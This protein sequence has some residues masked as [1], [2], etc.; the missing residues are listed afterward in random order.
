MRRTNARNPSGLI[1]GRAQHLFHVIDGQNV[2]LSF[3][4]FEF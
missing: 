4:R 2:D 3:V 1:R